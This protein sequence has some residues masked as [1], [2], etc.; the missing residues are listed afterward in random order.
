MK[1]DVFISYRRSTGADDAR[2]LQ[3]ALKAR[4]S[5]AFFNYDLRL[6]CGN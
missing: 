5:S 3:Q 2:L 4:G 1:Y 6:D